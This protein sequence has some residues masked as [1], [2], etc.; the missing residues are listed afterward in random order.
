ML[1]FPLSTRRSPDIDL[2][3]REHI[4]AT[5]EGITTYQSR[6]HIKDL[7]RAG[8]D[9]KTT[10]EHDVDGDYGLWR[11][12]LEGKRVMTGFKIGGVS[13]RPASE[14]EQA[15]TGKAWIATATPCKNSG[16]DLR[17][18]L[19]LLVRMTRQVEA[20]RMTTVGEQAA[21][22]HRFAFDGL[23]DIDDP[24]AQEITTW[25]H[26][27]RARAMTLVA[28]TGADDGALLGLSVKARSMTTCGTPR[29]YCRSRADLHSFGQPVSARP[30]PPPDDQIY[31]RPTEPPE[32]G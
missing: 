16:G 25:V 18:G 1:W 21:A 29:L 19:P 23:A 13:Y 20:A 12:E 22:V 17:E 31:W 7:R 10:S 11:S 14:R 28:T 30:T 9:I 26:D 5:I 4:A 27:H 24:L 32:H 15:H 8:R 3:L 2:R 6:T